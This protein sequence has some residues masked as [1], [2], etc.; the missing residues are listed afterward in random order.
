MPLIVIRP[1]TILKE[2]LRV[3]IAEERFGISRDDV[4]TK[5]KY[6]VPLALLFTLSLRRRAPDYRS[7][8][9]TK[10]PRSFLR[11]TA[12]SSRSAGLNVTSESEMGNITKE[13]SPANKSKFS[14]VIKS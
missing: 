3:R 1:P 2:N 14:A 4:R 13:L 7:T 10:L 12:I 8:S 11:S 5:G 6:T 9:A